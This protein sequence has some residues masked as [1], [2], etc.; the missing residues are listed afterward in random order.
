MEENLR[1]V[2]CEFKQLLSLL[3]LKDDG[4]KELYY[5]NSDPFYRIFNQYKDIETF[6][7]KEKDKINTIKHLYFGKDIIHKI[8][9]E[10]DKN[11]KITY[12]D[13]KQKS[14]AFNFYLNLLIN[15]NTEITNYT[16]SFDYIN[17]L[18][19]EQKKIKE[20]YKLILNAKII[21][22]LI[23]NFKN[24]DEYNEDEH[25]ELLENIEI[26][27]KK[28]LNINI[29]FD[30]TKNLNDIYTEI[31]VGLIKNRKF[32]DYEYTLNIL[33]QLDLNQIDLTDEMF[34][35]LYNFFQSNE[36]IIN[37]YMIINENDLYDEKKLNFNYILFKYI[38]KSSKYIYQFPFLLKTRKN[39]INLLKKHIILF[40]IENNII[41]NEGKLYS[42]LKFIV[43]SDY[44]IKKYIDENYY[45][46]NKDNQNNKNNQ[47][48]EIIEYYDYEFESKKNNINY[49]EY[50]IIN[51][52][53]K[54]VN[55]YDMN[56]RF[57]IKDYISICDNN[58][59]E[60][61]EEKL[62]K[63]INKWKDFG[64]RIKNN[65]RKNLRKYSKIKI[66]QYL[67][68]K[69]FNEEQKKN[70]INNNIK[71]ILNRNN[72]NKIYYEKIYI[73]KEIDDFLKKIILYYIDNIISNEKN[74]NKEKKGKTKT[75]LDIIYTICEFAN[76]LR[77]QL[78]II[79]HNVYIFFDPYKESYLYLKEINDN[80]IDLNESKNSTKISEKSYQEIEYKKINLNN[81][82]LMKKMINNKNNKAYIYL[83]RNNN[84]L[85]HYENNN[86]I[87]MNGLYNIFIYDINENREKDE[88]KSIQENIT[89]NNNDKFK[90]N[91]FCS[92]TKI[93]NEK[94]ENISLCLLGGS[95]N[96][97]GKIKLY[98]YYN[99][100]YK[101]IQDIIIKNNNDIYTIQPIN[102]L[103]VIENY[104]N[105]D[106]IPLEN[107][108]EKNN[109]KFKI[110]PIKP[111]EIYEK[112]DN[113]YAIGYT[114]L[115]KDIK[116]NYYL[117]VQYNNERVEVFD[118]NI[119]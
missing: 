65:N 27:N 101:Y 115:A 21:L 77:E 6:I 102:H 86:L 52:Y 2:K 51:N 54:H 61:T 48:T 66:I 67:L 100:T 8:L 57:S 91:C 98:S 114:E 63:V 119:L 49:I 41:R 81:I 39:I 59:K 97:L 37:D 113:N 94:N 107:I 32:E 108:T 87:I 104:N 46:I 40:E 112:K 50:M 74:E 82:T 17:K 53:E 93:Q 85:L 16:Y 14:L 58:K 34:Q 12:E 33:N 44:Y 3:L 4:K 9:Y 72:K 80:K 95:E 19:D 29:I 7:S 103:E 13:E 36:R 68:V 84:V 47:L 26:E 42:I 96:G 55:D 22:D 20:K 75:F 24:T 111:L 5:E 23:N 1:S 110:P 35:E 99:K 60:K 90:L 69:T 70:L 73:D 89:D 45:K 28:L 105:I 117:F 116:K 78:S 11:I 38:L 64:K 56:E 92:L 30:E 76:S 106:D 10:F 79:M 43:D 83:L 88:L 25:E 71:F 31:I 18:N 62:A 109:K 118:L 15:D